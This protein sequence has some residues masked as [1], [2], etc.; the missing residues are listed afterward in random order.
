MS[1]PE[2]TWED[3]LRFYKH[4][5]TPEYRMAF[6]LSRTPG[7]R[8][9]LFRQLKILSAEDLAASCEGNAE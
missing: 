4:I 3:W 7:E 5:Q 9:E 1:G 8:R 6:W 2:N